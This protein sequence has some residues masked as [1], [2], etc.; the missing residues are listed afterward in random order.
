MGTSASLTVAG[1]DNVGVYLGTRRF[2]RT[3]AAA[4]WVYDSRWPDLVHPSASAIDTK[5][6]EAPELCHIMLNYRAP[7]VPLPP[8]GPGHQHFDEY[9]DQSIEEWHRARGLWLP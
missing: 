8:A 1:G 9:P 4:L 3:C 6:P 2:C 7:W 5:L